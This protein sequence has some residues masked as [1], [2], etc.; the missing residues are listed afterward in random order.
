MLSPEVLEKI[1]VSIIT[2]LQPIIDQRLKELAVDV[3]KLKGDPPPVPSAL[4]QR[5]K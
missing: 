4:M 5:G 2:N 1:Q 3:N